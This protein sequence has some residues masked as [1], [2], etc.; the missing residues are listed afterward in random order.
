MH[1][2][3]S[4][5]NLHLPTVGGQEVGNLGPV[6]GPVSFA[7]APGPEFAEALR[8]EVLVAQTA[9]PEVL[10]AAEGAGRR[11]RRRAPVPRARATQIP[12]AP[13]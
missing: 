6:L 1:Q 9:G 5:V 7:P 11:P 3:K 8:P 12:L 13:S 2:R 4:G 10:F